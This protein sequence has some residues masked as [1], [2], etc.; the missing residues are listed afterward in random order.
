M[1]ECIADLLFRR[2]RKIE[3]QGGEGQGG[4][5]GMGREGGVR[6]NK[7]EREG[8]GGREGERDEKEKKKEENRRSK[9]QEERPCAAIGAAKSLSWS[10]Q[11]EKPSG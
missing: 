4:E 1:S 11:P 2:K 7:G 8:Q 3:G 6:D 10:C 9:A 5:G